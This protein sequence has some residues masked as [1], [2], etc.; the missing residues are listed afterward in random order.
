VQKEMAVVVAHG[1]AI[2]VRLRAPLLLFEG[3][4]YGKHQSTGSPLPER[5]ALRHY[6][7]TKIHRASFAQGHL[8]KGKAH[9]SIIEA[10]YGDFVKRAE[11]ARCGSQSG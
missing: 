6:L 11:A 5:K 8:P 4:L 2:T 10:P 7:A 3:N 1:L 9:F